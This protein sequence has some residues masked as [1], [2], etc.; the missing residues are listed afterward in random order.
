MNLANKITMARVVMI[1]VFCAVYMGSFMT[2]PT[3]SYA[4]LAIFAVASLS[5][6]LDGYVARSRNLITN[7]G[8]FADPLADKLLVC[9]ALVCMVE[10]GLL[11]SWVV[12]LILSREFIITGFRTVAAA[13]NIVI[14]A[15]WWG[16][17]KTVSQ[18]AM[19]IVV[20]SGFGNNGGQLVVIML[21]LITVT[22]TVISGVDYIFKNKAVLKG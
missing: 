3:R 1:P 22:L 17:A 18:M 16:K 10:K 13:E 8:K 12:I 11:A 6:W 9:A 5:D 21:I 14:A 4:A 2:E 15:S 7:F 19:I 20:M